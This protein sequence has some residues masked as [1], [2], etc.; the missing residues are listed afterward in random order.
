MNAIIPQNDAAAHSPEVPCEQ[1]E[2]PIRSVTWTYA[3]LSAQVARVKLPR[4]GIA[5]SWRASERVGDAYDGDTRQVDF[6]LL[7]KKVS[8]ISY[9][10]ASRF[11]L[12]LPDRNAYKE[13]QNEED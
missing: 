3:R 8:V 1:A 4:N 12:V 10:I 5:G 9:E 13:F 11:I 2:P 7:P 6:G